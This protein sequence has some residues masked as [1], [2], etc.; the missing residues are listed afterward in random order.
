MATAARGSELGMESWGEPERLP[1]SYSKTHNTAP[2]MVPD[3]SITSGWLRLQRWHRREDMGSGM[4]VLPGEARG[5]KSL[6]L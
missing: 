5:F 1:K 3:S 6:A 2:A 4:S